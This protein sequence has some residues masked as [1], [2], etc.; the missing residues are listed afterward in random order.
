MKKGDLV[1]IYSTQNPP[2]KAIVL[3]DYKGD[4]LVRV[5]IPSTG[6]KRTCHASQV[7]LHKR[8]QRPTLSTKDKDENQTTNE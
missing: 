2:V 1:R 4:K 8:A 3:E 5:Y 6:E 7:Q